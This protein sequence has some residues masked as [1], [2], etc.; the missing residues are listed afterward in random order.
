MLAIISHPD[1]LLHDPGERHPEDA[2]RLHA[3]NN[4]LI[5]SGLEFVV[6]HYDAP[7]ADRAALGRV[8][9]E[10]HI[11][12]IFAAAPRDGHVTLDDDTIMSPGTLRAA[13]RAVGAGMLG[14]DLVM[15]GE[16]ATAF[17]NVRPP[18]H[19]AG[20]A[21]AGGF[22]LFNNVA[23]AAAY[24]LDAYGLSRVAIV[25][26]DVHHGDGLEDIFADDPRVLLCSSFQH[27]LYP[28][29]GHDSQAANLVG[30][31]LPAGTDGPSWRAAVGPAWLPALR[32]FRPQILF[33][34]AGFDAHA[35]DD[36]ASLRLSEA[37]YGWITGELAAIAA[38]CASGRIVS[39]LEGGYEHGALA[40]SAIAHARAL[41]GQG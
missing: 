40:R 27:P 15:S 17:C 35:L 2:G 23:A 34:A 4:Q 14:V 19:H 31:P 6:R 16:A 28:H 24:A 39:M 3:I 10:A 32:A 25:D 36:M 12:R 8:H 5:M 18:G 20:R 22:C 13:L 21:H 30:V 11:D 33:I 38:E 7:L 37:D 41:A 9:D 1:C 29:R 26:F